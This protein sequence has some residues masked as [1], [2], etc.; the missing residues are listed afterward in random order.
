MVVNDSGRTKPADRPLLR[1]RCVQGKIRQEGSRRSL[2][3]ARKAKKAAAPP[4]VVETR[5]GASSKPVSS[6]SLG[7]NFEVIRK[8]KKVG[9]LSA[10][11]RSSVD[12]SSST[13]MSLS[14]PPPPPG[15]MAPIRFADDL[16]RQSKERCFSSVSCPIRSSYLLFA[17]PPL[18]N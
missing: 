17:K 16:E 10:E 6:K 5:R 8:T 7:G 2:Q 1:S 9:T 18:I 12:G 15:D 11:G 4:Q 3:A 14:M 13:E